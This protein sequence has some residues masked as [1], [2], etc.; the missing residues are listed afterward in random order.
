MKFE[1]KYTGKWVAVKSNKVIASEKT[2]TK[3]TKKVKNR[4]D[5][6]TLHFTLIPNSI[7]AG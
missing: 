7:I 6:N 5:Q 2:L 1:K 3:L 4:K